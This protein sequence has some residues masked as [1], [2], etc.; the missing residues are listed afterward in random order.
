MNLPKIFHELQDTGFVF[1]EDSLSYYSSGQ[2][3]SI[4]TITKEGTKMLVKVYTQNDGHNRMT[5]EE[6]GLKMLK[7]TNTVSIP[8]IYFAE[9]LYSGALLIMK[10]VES[11]HPHRKSMSLLGTQLAQLHL[12]ATKSCFGLN[13][14]N[15]IGALDQ[16]NKPYKKWSAFYFSCRLKPQIDMAISRGL[17]PNDTISNENDWIDTIDKIYPLEQ[18]SLI[19]GDLWSGNL[20][21]DIEGLPYLIDPAVAYSHREL[22]IAMSKLFGGFSE[23]FYASYH[24]VYPLA[25]GFFER[26]ELSQLY[27]LLVHVNL[28]GKSYVSQTRNLLRQY[29]G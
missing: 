3:G 18:A 25:D 7:Q 26:M 28:F 4:Y 22:D 13:R 17:L 10:Y 21:T 20:V 2:A 19:H 14:H 27:Y 24:E 11:S 23:D 16:C 29:F 9:K 1:K 15:Y 12:S 5:A 6:D 8:E